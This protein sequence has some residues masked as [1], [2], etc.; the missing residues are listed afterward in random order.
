MDQRTAQSL[1]KIAPLGTL[2]LTHYGRKSGQPYDV[3][4]WFVVEGQ[5]MYLGTAKRVATGSATSW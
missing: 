5:K 4:I 1:A 2:T 3:I